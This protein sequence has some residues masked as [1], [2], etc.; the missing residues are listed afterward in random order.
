MGRAADAVFPVVKYLTL[1]FPFFRIHVLEDN[2]YLLEKKNS[3]SSEKTCRS[4]INQKGYYI[5]YNEFF[6]AELLFSCATQP[7]RFQVV[8]NTGVIL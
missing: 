6:F 7:Y 8:D 2:F 3:T 5:L 4:Y 1:A